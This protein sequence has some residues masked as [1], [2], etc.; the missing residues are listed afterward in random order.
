MLQLVLSPGVFCVCVCV[1]LCG[2]LSYEIE[3]SCECGDSSL[4]PMGTEVFSS[5]YR[6]D[7]S[8]KVRIKAYLGLG[9]RLDIQL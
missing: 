1:R 4:V 3:T 6:L 8:V 2:Y 7:F 5:V 9:L